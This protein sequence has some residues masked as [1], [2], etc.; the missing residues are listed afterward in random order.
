MPRRLATNVALMF[1]DGRGVP[2]ELT[3]AHFWLNLA[4]AGAP[5][6]EALRYMALNERRI[7]TQR[8][9]AVQLKEAQDRAKA[10]W[11]RRSRR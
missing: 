4:A 9:S 7:V 5:P 1:R 3:Q 8:L 6:F 2:P 11:A 10:W